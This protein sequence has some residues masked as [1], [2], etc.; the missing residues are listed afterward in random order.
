MWFR[1]VTVGAASLLVGAGSA[2]AHEGHGLLGAHG[3]STDGFGL[4]LVGLLVAA[5]LWLGRK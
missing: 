1:S 2:W 5:A 3:H 4:V